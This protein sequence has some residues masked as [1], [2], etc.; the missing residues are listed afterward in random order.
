MSRFRCSVFLVLLVLLALPLA[1]EE[2]VD[3]A[4]GEYVTDG[5]WGRLVV[6]RHS[7]GYMTFM[8]DTTG[9]NGHM[10]SLQGEVTGSKA[11]LTI[12]D[13]G[14][15][16]VTFTTTTD[17][18]DVNR[19]GESCAGY[20]GARASFDAL[21]LKPA[22]GCAPRAVALTRAKFLRLYDKR[23]W[24]AATKL[25]EPVLTTCA[26]T[27]D[28]LLEGWIRNDIAIA[29]HKLKDFDACRAVLEPLA[30]DAA[31]SE[32]QLREHYPPSDADARMPLLRATRTN[33][34][35]CSGK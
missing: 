20:C 7:L 32:K 4:E 6:K 1:A 14:S 33:L 9:A 19:E 23:N 5:G 27:L 17:G 12:E 22:P 13:E 29:L 8:I 16:V 24:T 21:Y 30:E 2:P 34:A 11:T 28:P 10:C 26:R 18:I 35:L 3:L 15:C 25:L 31:S